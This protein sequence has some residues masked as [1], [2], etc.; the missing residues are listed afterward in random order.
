[1]PIIYRDNQPLYFEDTGGDGPVIVFS[2]SFGMNGAMFAPQTAFFRN[3]YRCISW[4]E[5]AHGQSPASADFDFW[6]SARDCLAIVNALGIDKASFVGVSQ[7]GFLTLRLALL[8]PERVSSLAILGSSASAE[9]EEQKAAS[10]GMSA[11]FAASPNGPPEEVLEILADICFSGHEAA[12]EWKG[13]WRNW[14]ASQSV[15][16]THAL[17]ERDDIRSRLAEITAPSMVLHGDNDHA[18]DVG[19]ATE[20]ASLLGCCD[21]EVIIPGGAHFLSLTNPDEV[22]AYLLRFLETHS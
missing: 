13:V 21:G 7:G 2:H 15:K 22:N 19:H 14:P 11:A 18:Y 17:V 8:E 6:E 10:L 1:M 12:S 5:R 16:A 9:T 4:D 20:L 3:R